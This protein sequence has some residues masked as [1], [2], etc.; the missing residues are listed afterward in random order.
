MNHHLSRGNSQP[1][2]KYD[3][4]VYDYQ[5]QIGNNFRVYFS[6]QATQTLYGGA[7]PCADST[8]RP[9][10]DGLTCPIGMQPPP[11]TLSRPANL[12]IVPNPGS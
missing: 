10:I 7:A 2:D 6:E 4:F 1:H 8:S 12:R 5:G 3:V 9:E 11:G